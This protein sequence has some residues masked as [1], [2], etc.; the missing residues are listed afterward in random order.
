MLEDYAPDCKDFSH[1]PPYVGYGFEFLSDVSLVTF[2]GSAVHSKMKSSTS[3][4]IRDDASVLSIDGDKLPSYNPITVPLR[5][6]P[7]QSPTFKYMLLHYLSYEPPS[8]QQWLK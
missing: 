6:P 3:R 8:A 7:S 1:S 2:V 4:R 5:R